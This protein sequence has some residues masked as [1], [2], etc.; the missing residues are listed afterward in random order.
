MLTVITQSSVCWPGAIDH[1]ALHRWLAEP[2]ARLCPMRHA[3]VAFTHW[4]RV[5]LTTPVYANNTNDMQ[6]MH[7]RLLSKVP[8]TWCQA[9]SGLAVEICDG[10]GRHWSV[11]VR[12][13]RYWV[14]GC[15]RQDLASLITLRVSRFIQRIAWV[16]DSN[17]QMSLTL[18]TNRVL[19]LSC[20]VIFSL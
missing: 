8:R 2:A 10:A 20:T 1:R 18:L 6:R 4:I 16:D 9:V 11:L 15:D 14:D 13:Q 17:Q 5:G 7:H 19:T 3:S 12:D